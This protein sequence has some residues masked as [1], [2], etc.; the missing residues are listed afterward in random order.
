M[1]FGLMLEDKSSGQ[2]L[3]GSGGCQDFLSVRYE[4]TAQTD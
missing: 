2:I 4:I 1:C 3:D